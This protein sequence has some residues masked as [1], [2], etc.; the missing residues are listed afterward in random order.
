MEI[1]ANI[2]QNSGRSLS[3]SIESSGKDLNMNVEKGVGTYT[4]TTTV[5]PTEET[6][7]LY[8]AGFMM[9]S[10]VTINPIPSNYGKITWNGSVLTVS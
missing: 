5:T 6:Q 7:T 2:S 10:N 3:I 1:N 9:N 8:T 4:G